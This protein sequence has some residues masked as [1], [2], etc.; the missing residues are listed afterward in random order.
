MNPG[1]FGDPGL[2]RMIGLNQ[3][4]NKNLYHGFCVIT[5][6][7]NFIVPDGVFNVWVTQS[8]GGQGGQ[9]GQ[10]G[11]GSV[12]GANGASGSPGQGAIRF[13][14]PV[15]PGAAVP[16]VVGAGGTGGAAGVGSG[17]VGSIGALGGATSF[18]SYLTTPSATMSAQIFGP[19]NGV[20]GGT[21]GV[22]STP[23]TVPNGAPGVGGHGGRY[24]N[25]VLS[26]AGGAGSPGF[27]FV[28][29]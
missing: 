3:G 23:S 11:D 6:S 16:C 10:N 27:I 29:W 1:I 22:A 5:T 17:G 2:G 13:S 7:G 21:Y 28:E 24:D 20:M 19:G 14:V 4:E 15:V 18:G 12:D 26:V 9:G 25:G 8:S